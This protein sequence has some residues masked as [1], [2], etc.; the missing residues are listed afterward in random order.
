M[1]AGREP[2]RTVLVAGA[3]WQ[4]SMALASRSEPRPRHRKAHVR[5]RRQHRP[6][7]LGA[8][9]CVRVRSGRRPA[10]GVPQ[11]PDITSHSVKNVTPPAGGPGSGA[12]RR[13]RAAMMPRRAGRPGG[14]QRHLM[15]S[16]PLVPP[17]RSQPAHESAPAP[18]HPN[19]RATP[20][21]G[22]PPDRYA[23]SPTTG[24]TRP[25][26]PRAHAA[27]PLWRQATRA[28]AAGTG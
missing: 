10:P 19:P 26:R 14:A 22:S 20:G 18:V 4:K 23:R 16:F 2:P 6:A 25:T 13:G 11:F 7:G 17:R 5:S 3:P 27:M 28:G 1:S 21:P 9:M 8:G 24:M 15:G 12:S